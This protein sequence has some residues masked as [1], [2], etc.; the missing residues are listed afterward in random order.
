MGEVQGGVG[1]CD[2]CQE[3]RQSSRGVSVS[4]EV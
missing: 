4:G 3:V 2:N 1:R